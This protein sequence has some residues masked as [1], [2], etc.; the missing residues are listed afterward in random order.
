[1]RIVSVGRVSRR[2]VGEGVDAD[3]LQTPGLT[4][5]YCEMWFGGK[6]SF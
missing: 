3:V 2:K 5:G 6:R 1:M 4:L